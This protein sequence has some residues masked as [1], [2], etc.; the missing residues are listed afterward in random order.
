VPAE[1]AA[2]P[3]DLLDRDF[4]ASAPNQRW[5]AD[6]TYVATWH[7]FC[8]VAFVLDLFSRRIVG[9]SIDASPTAALVTNASSTACGNAAARNATW[10]VWCTILTAACRANS[11][12]RRNTSMREVGD[13]PW[14]EAGT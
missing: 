8:Y 11:T 13:G 14:E 9:W 7:G 6:I 3:G 5:V 1:V 4:T 10:P 12:G 2:R